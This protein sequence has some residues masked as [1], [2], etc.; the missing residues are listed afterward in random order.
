MWQSTR[1]SG[2]QR[3]RTLRTRPRSSGL[4]SFMASRLRS[5]FWPLCRTPE[6]FSGP[7]WPMR[8]RG[9]ILSL[10]SALKIGRDE[11]D[12]LVEIGELG[13]EDD[14]AGEHQGR[15]LA[16]DLAGVDIGLDVD[17]DA[18]VVAQGQGVLG[19]GLADDE[20]RDVA[21]LGRR[22][23]RL[24]PDER[25][26]LLEVA[27]EGDDVGVGRRRGVVGRFGGR[28][29]APRPEPGAGAA[30]GRREAAGSAPGRWG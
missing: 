13:I 3:W 25:R 27:D 30:R 26:E 11:Q 8:F 16:L 23:D 5:R 14:V 21:A 22:A 17:D 12:D 7:T 1:S 9:S 20:E 10:P 28:L 15:F 29:R 18:L 4:S 2:S 6:P 19:Q 24:D